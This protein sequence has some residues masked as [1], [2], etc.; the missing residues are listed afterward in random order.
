MLAQLVI[1]YGESVYNI[2]WSYPA[3]VVASFLVPWGIIRTVKGIKLGNQR[4][5][6][7]AQIELAAQAIR[8]TEM[9][10]AEALEIRKSLPGIWWTVYQSLLHI[11]DRKCR[12]STLE[13]M[14]RPQDGKPAQIDPAQNP[15]PPAGMEII[16]GLVGSS[17]DFY[18]RH[19]LPV[20]TTE[21][22]RMQP[23]FQLADLK[24]FLDQDV[25]TMPLE[26]AYFYDAD[27]VSNTY[28][29]KWRKQYSKNEIY[30]QIG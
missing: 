20:Y 5:S 28:Y 6:E 30:S 10:H 23:E 25:K 21:W 15:L 13:R 12:Q 24:Q 26:E 11:S 14:I 29:E 16:L 2:P 27:V 19:Y 9:A 4:R 1:N 22:I 3:Y 17:D 7:H 18:I 8:Q